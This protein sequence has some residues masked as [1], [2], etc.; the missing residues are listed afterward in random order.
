MHIVK[1]IFF[2]K[3]FFFEFIS[4]KFCRLDMLENANIAFTIAIA[5]VVVLF[6]IAYNLLFKKSPIEST[7]T[8]IETTTSKSDQIADQVR[9]N[10]QQ[11][12]QQQKEKKQVPKVATKSKDVPFKHKLLS[13]CLKAHSDKV[14][15]NTMKF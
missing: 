12:Q 3:F 13:S 14:N 10:K 2:Q 1:N 8:N 7:E 9:S 11:Q 4:I 15:G 6:Y 5:T